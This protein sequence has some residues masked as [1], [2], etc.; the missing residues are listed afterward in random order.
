MLLT[1]RADTPNFHQTG[2]FQLPT[3]TGSEIRIILWD[4]QK[5]LISLHCASCYAHPLYKWL[6][7][8]FQTK[9]HVTY[10]TDCNRQNSLFLSTYSVWS[11]LMRSVSSMLLSGQNKKDLIQKPRHL[12]QRRREDVNLKVV[13]VRGR[14]GDRAPERFNVCTL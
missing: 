10:P 9:T 1:L 8:N 14:C 5:N 11:N 6:M 4:I 2:S 3:N 7:Y 12:F 13:G